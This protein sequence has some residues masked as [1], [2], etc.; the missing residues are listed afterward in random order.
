MWDA[1]AERGMK[2]T[3]T[4]QFP[5]RECVSF[6]QIYKISPSLSQKAGDHMFPDC[7]LPV[8][9][10]TSYLVVLQVENIIV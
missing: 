1:D 5:S 4:L 9:L 10:N 7:N 6:H 3:S 8:H 2:P